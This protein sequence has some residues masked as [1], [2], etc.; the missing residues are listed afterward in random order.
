M[1]RD[2]SGNG[3]GANMTT[4]SIESNG[5]WNYSYSGYVALGG[6]I[7]EAN[8]NRVMERVREESQA[9]LTHSSL[10]QQTHVTAEISGISLD[11]LSEETSVDARHIYEILRHDVRPKDVEHHHGSMSDQQ[12]LVESLRMLEQGDA[13]EAIIATHPHMPFQ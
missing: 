1:Y 3:E 5:E 10:A 6:R 7:D 11:A 4:P 9:G 13:A 12:L 2:I 8:Y